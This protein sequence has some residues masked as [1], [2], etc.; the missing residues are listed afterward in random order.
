MNLKYRGWIIRINDLYRYLK[1][2]P[3]TIVFV[4]DSDTRALVF[5]V[6][7]DQDQEGENCLPDSRHPPGL[8]MWE[9][10]QVSASSQ[11]ILTTELLLLICGRTANWSDGDL[12]TGETRLVPPSCQYRHCRPSAGFTR[13]QK[14]QTIFISSCPL[15][16]SVWQPGAKPSTINDTSLFLSVFIFTSQW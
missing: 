6:G 5:R 4:S 1:I 13:Y 10:W 16:L 15:S 11:T 8:T 7:A 2:P 12:S 14:L 9:V 3:N